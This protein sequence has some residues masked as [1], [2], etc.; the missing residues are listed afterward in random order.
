M[1]DSMEIDASAAAAA[2]ADH[3][4]A[5]PQAEGT[6]PMD[7]NGLEDADK[8]A[9]ECGGR[10]VN[11]CKSAFTCRVSIPDGTNSQA[12]HRLSDA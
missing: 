11:A 12:V 1:A 9:E 2:G 10:C 6:Q 7:A 4:G 3:D 5:E 8:G